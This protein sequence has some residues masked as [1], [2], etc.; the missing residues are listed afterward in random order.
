MK[1][2]EQLRNLEGLFTT[3]ARRSVPTAEARHRKPSGQG[4]Q[5]T[6]EDD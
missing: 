4:D 3:A 1:A 5:R 6:N 2:E